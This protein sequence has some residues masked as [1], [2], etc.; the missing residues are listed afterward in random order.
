MSTFKMGGQSS[1]S[2]REMMEYLMEIASMAAMADLGK[3]AAND[4]MPQNIREIMPILM[5]VTVEAYI[6]AAMGQKEGMAMT[7]EEVNAVIRDA[8]MRAFGF[9][10]E[11]GP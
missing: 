10:D 3:R 8:S 6:V 2:P 1:M 4:E 7:K 11:S 9:L 5:R